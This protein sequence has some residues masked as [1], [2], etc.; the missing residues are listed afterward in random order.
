VL[1]DRSG[2]TNTLASPAT[3]RVYPLSALWVLDLPTWEPGDATCPRCAA[4]EPIETPG[5]TGAAGLH[6]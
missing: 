1:V 3:G 5:S 4:G 2:G 6:G